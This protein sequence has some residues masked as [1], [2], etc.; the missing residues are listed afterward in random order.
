MRRRHLARMAGEA[1]GFAFAEVG[2][3]RP[4]DSRAR[5]KPTYRNRSFWAILGR[6]FVAFG[7][8]EGENRGWRKGNKL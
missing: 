5:A 3:V 8:A 2:N 1:A 6:N 7:V 4:G